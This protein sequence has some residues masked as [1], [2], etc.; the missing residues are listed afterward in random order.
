VAPIFDR[1]DESRPIA[2]Q[3]KFEGQNRRTRLFDR[4][5]HLGP[6]RIFFIDI[7]ELWGR[8]VSKLRRP[9]SSPSS[10]KTLDQLKSSDLG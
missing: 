4:R 5:K 3:A 1:R 9:L 7:Q 6:S 2:M 10:P 8:I